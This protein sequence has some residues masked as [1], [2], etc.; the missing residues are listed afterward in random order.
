[1][2]KINF[3]IIKNF[4]P[5]VFKIKIPNKILDALNNY[6]DEIVNDQ[7]KSKDL[8]IGKNLVGDV[9]QEF[10]LDKDFIKKSD[11]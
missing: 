11:W 9:T 10:K 5:S 4:G 3:K 6:I 8:D 1:M 7:N 2:E